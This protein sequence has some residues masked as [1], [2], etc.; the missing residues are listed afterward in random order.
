MFVVAGGGMS[1]ILVLLIVVLGPWRAT[2][3]ILVVFCL[4][5]GFMT[6]NIH[7]VIDEK[8]IGKIP[9][10]HW[11]PPASSEKWINHGGN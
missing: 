3:T 7:P 8:P 6:W 5:A 4:V 10:W 2:C 1:A 11:I 9:P